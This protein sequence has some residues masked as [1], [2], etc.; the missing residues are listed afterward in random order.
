MTDLL[1]IITQKID[2]P[3]YQIAKKNNC[4]IIAHDSDI[5]GRYSVF[6]SVGIIPAVIAG[7]DVKKFYESLCEI[8]SWDW[9]GAKLVIEHCDSYTEMNKE[10]QKGFLQ[11]ADELKVINNETLK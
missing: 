4:E 3:L 11:L 7:V 10:P 2:S 6:S 1:L 9:N 5:G 8:C